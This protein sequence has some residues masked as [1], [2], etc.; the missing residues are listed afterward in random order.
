[1]ESNIRGSWGLKCGRL[2]API[3]P[4]TAHT[5]P[6]FTRCTPGGPTSIA[7]HS[8]APSVR[9]SHV[10]SL[11]LLGNMGFIQVAGTLHRLFLLCGTR[12]FFKDACFRFSFASCHLLKC[13]VF[14][15][16]FTHLPAR[17]NTS[18]SVIFFFCS[19]LLSSR[20]MCSFYYCIL[21]LLSGS[22]TRIS[23]LSGQ[24]F[25]MSSFTR[26]LLASAK[27]TLGNKSHTRMGGPRRA[28]ELGPALGASRA[29]C[30]VAFPALQ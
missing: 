28:P 12:S 9:L 3:I 17:Y 10:S 19:S 13:L 7:Y 16:P 29:V 6:S 21:L 27:A 4:P 2:W 11:G 24:S 18:V 14:P 30:A 26:V 15:K 23:T 5:D 20:N 1:M 22:L 8:V 25:N